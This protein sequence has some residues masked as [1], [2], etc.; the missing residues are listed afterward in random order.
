MKI[1]C[2]LLFFFLS[3]DLIISEAGKLQL[4]YQDIQVLEFILEFN[5]IELYKYNK[6][7]YVNVWG[8]LCYAVNYTEF[9]DKCRLKYKGYN[10]K[11]VVI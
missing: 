8:K 4:K 5:N 1:F 10:N 3:F 9:E 2:N 6:F 7:E 11:W